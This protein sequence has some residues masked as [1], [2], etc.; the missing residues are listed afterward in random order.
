MSVKTGSH[1]SIV[2]CRLSRNTAKP[3]VETY[4]KMILGSRSSVFPSVETHENHW[5]ERLERVDM[6]EI[7]GNH[8]F[9]EKKKIKEKP[10]QF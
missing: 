6:E 8:G 10:T 3:T 7:H 4:V 2:D 1:N 9:G 5:N